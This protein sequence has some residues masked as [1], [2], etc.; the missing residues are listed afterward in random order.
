MSYTGNYLPES[1]LIF[2]FSGCVTSAVGLAVTAFMLKEPDM[3]MRR[4]QLSNEHV[5]ST[6]QQGTAEHQVPLLDSVQT[7]QQAE[8]KLPM[9]KRVVNA[10]A[11]VQVGL[12]MIVE[13]VVLY[14]LL[15][16]L[17][18]T[19]YFADLIYFSRVC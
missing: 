9:R 4:E 15:V 8:Q 5:I 16:F 12:H 18:E 2:P 7:K 11:A 3:G 10:W 17:N 1:F 6:N 14:L 13:L 19:F